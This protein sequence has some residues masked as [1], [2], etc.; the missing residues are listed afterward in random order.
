MSL[1]VAYKKDDTVYMCADTQTTIGICKTN[2]LTN[3]SCKIQKFA[4]GML[5]GRAGNVCS[6]QFVTSHEEWF[7]LP[8]DGELTKEHIVTHILPKIYKGLDEIGQLEEDKYGIKN[9]KGAFILA[10]KDKLFFVS[11]E[12][13]VITIAKFFQT[14]A[15]M[16]LPAQF[17][18]RINEDEDINE[19]LLVAMRTCSKFNSSISGPYV[20]INTKDSTYQYVD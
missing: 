4:N 10:H 8:E 6:N 14:G 2:Y 3:S 15:V 17:L 1:I 16:G 7:T 9:M 18:N 12:F 13:F 5:V 11:E 19:Q 20:L